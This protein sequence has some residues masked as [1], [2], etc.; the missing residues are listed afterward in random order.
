MKEELT[1]AMHAE[2]EVSEETDRS[3]RALSLLRME[4]RGIKITDKVLEG[5]PFGREEVEKYRKHWAHLLAK[6]D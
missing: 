6:K 5:Y 2:F 3:L 4:K 1:T